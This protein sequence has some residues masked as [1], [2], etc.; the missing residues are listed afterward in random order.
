MRGFFGFY[1]VMIFAFG[2]TGALGQVSLDSLELMSIKSDTLTVRRLLDE[3]NELLTSQKLDLALL[4]LDTAHQI[5][6]RANSQNSLLYAD[7]LSLEGLAF[8][9]KQRI[10]QALDKFT[11]S[12]HIR[13]LNLTIDHP[14]LASSYLYMGNSLAIKGE[15]DLAIEYL[16]KALKIRTLLKNR[17]NV[18]IAKIYSG[19]GNCFRNKSDYDLSISFQEKALELLVPIHGVWLLFDV[20]LPERKEQCQHNT[21][22]KQTAA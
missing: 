14:D 17:S 9:N 5:L 16:Y 11:E 22:L 4:K 1:F 19:L 2:A 6:L 13:E 3:S 18:D 20:H 21:N 10:D 15:T 7:V 12:T 8:F